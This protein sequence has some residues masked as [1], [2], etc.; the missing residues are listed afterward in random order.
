MSPFK[1]LGRRF[2]V[3]LFGIPLLLAS[4]V[5]GKIFFLS[6]SG[7]ILSVAL[8]E[9]YK[10]A[11]KKGYTPLKSAGLVA[12]LAV[13][14]DFY[15]WNA[16]WFQWILFIEWMAVLGVGLFQKNKNH[17]ANA[18]VTV[19]GT[20]YLS[21]FSY[22]IL[23]RQL[24][25]YTDQPY[26]KGGLFIMMI[27]IAIWICDTAAYFVGSSLGKHKLFPRVSPRKTW[28]G[29]VAG[30]IASP[31]AV[32]AFDRL[33]LKNLS[34]ADILFI[35]FIVGTIGQMSDLIES[36]FKRDVDVKDSSNL[37]PGHGGMLDRFD[38][39]LLVAP[40]IYFYLYIKYFV[41]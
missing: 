23:I 18:S 22:F 29:A 3:T 24:P 10:L 4:M 17:L 27:F 15:L 31:I 11:E 19:G 6:V 16:H 40:I 25:V 1:H 13:A 41:Q 21:C 36:L 20:L 39:P 9:L 38:S 30:F 33:F 14:I 7:V 8:W 28:E 35:G 2:L 34:L 5:V 12:V 32:W 37:L 26:E